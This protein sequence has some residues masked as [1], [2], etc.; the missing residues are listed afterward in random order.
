MWITTP[1]TE[2][3]ANCFAL[4]APFKPDAG[5]QRLALSNPQNRTI[6]EDVA[7]L[8]GEALI[9]LFDELISGWDRFSAVLKLH[10][11]SSRE[12][13]WRQLWQITTGRKAITS[14]T[15]IQN[16]G[17]TLSWIAW[18]QPSGAMRRLVQ[19][20]AAIPTELPGEYD[21]NVSLTE[22]RFSVTGVL[23][24]VKNACF[25]Q[26]S[27]WPSTQVSFPPGRTVHFAV[28][29]YLADA[30]CPI[31]VTNVG[32]EV[33][34][35]A[36]LDSESEADC[37]SADR[38]GALFTNC[39]AVFEPTSPY[40]PE[41]QRFLNSLREVKL[42]ARDDRYH[43]VEELVCSRAL[44][45]VIETDEVLRAAFAP[46]SALLASEYSDNALVFF[47]KTRGQLTA[48]SSVLAGWAREA[49]AHQLQAVFA[50]LIRGDLGQQVADQLKR[51]WLEA[52]RESS[53]WHKLSPEEQNEIERIFLKGYHWHLPLLV[54]PL[55]VANELV[56]AGDG[57]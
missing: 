26:V 45:N 39:R 13:W 34:V 23:A 21:R 2:R 15:S 41:V 24:E 46:P 5:R 10:E 48:G 19:Q 50:Y 7:Q 22:I 35:N 1:T 27:Q 25:S 11:D 56:E 12:H 28:A 32:L 30:E 55:E 47:T 38:I 20:R 16:G 40:S 18:G 36:A 52:K 42:R 53:A 14:W 17:E 29:A 51:P 31:T 8:W 9:E 37:A 49:D 44:S 3:S 4:N 57:R 33:V 43:A 6:A 54:E